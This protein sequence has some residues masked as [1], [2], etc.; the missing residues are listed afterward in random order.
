MTDDG[1]VSRR[2]RQVIAE[3]AISM[4]HNGGRPIALGM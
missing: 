1:R 2:S 3:T 4:L